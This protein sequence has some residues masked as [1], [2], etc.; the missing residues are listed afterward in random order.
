MLATLRPVSSD[1][2]G[3]SIPDPGFAGDDGRADAALVAAVAAHAADPAR[4]PEVLAALHRARVLAPVVALLGEAGSTADGPVHDRNADIAVPVLVDPEGARALPVFTDLA[5]LARW[6]PAARPVPVAG[7]RAA[8]V[9]LAEGAEALVLDLAGPSSVTLPLPE[10]RALAEGRAARPVWD[11]WEVAAAVA[12]VL[13]NEPAARSAHLAP[14]AGR[15][16]R[17]T[18]V[19]DPAAD[20]VAFATRLGAAVAALPALRGG[21][22]GLDVAV[23]TSPGREDPPC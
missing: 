5:A 7:P 23:T 12:G 20:Q 15:D 3:R 9:A 22:R 10:T 13:E 19:V 18:V 2:G 17:L 1:V 8:Q 4:L 21:V 6:D 11:D 16:A 14:C